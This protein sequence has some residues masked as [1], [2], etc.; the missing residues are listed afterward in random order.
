M[1]INSDIVS[2]RQGASAFDETN[3]LNETGHKNMLHLIHLRWLAVGG[4]IATILVATWGFGIQLPLFNMLAV[5]VCLIAFNIGSHLRWHEERVVSNRELFLAMLVDIASLTA[6]L[7]FTGGINNPFVFLF[8][9]QVILSA[10]LLRVESTWLVVAITTLCLAFLSIFN[11]P[12]VWPLNSSYKLA[13]LYAT[14]LV[15]CFVLNAAL[16]VIFITR[17]GRNLRAG[18]AALA[19]LRQRAVEEEHIVRMGLL[20]SGA[21]HELGTPLATMSVVLSDW[22]RMP[23]FSKDPAMLEEIEEIEGQLLRCKSIV[24]GILLSAGETRGES[25]SKTSLNEF[26]ESLV[27]EW[28][29]SRPA[30]QFEYTNSI[31]EEF[32]VAFD[33]TVK[34][35]VFNVLDNALE[36]SPNWLRFEVSKNQEQLFL[37]VADQGPGF[38]ADILEQVGTPYNSSKGRPGG[39]L[40]L[41]LV[42]NVART[43]GGTLTVNNRKE[44]GAE[45]VI[46]LPLNA[47]ILQENKSP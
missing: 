6:Q 3:V 42:M 17:I 2:I 4:Q 22:K 5:M 44:G 43:L 7:Y 39:G 10:V 36:V 19:G 18:D 1:A 37:T 46:A 41:F 15:I 33:S 11:K 25:S 8:L 45:V 9:L 40:G 14:G 23:Q 38:R 12:L 16:L 34:Q 26:F 31:D 47:M 20:A 29:S 32:T 21:A 30:Q 13:D 27:E 28:E 35:M 24:S